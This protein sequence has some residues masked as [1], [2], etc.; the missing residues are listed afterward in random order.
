[1]G[2]EV[3]EK[4]SG[5]D[6]SSVGG[7]A[8]VSAQGERVRFCPEEPLV[9]DEGEESEEMTSGEAGQPKQPFPLM[10]PSPQY[11]SKWLSS[12]AHAAVVNGSGQVLQSTAEN[13]ERLSSA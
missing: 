10:T 4:E 2:A 8:R 9:I 5:E 6:L 1:M 3:R 12:A 11:G 7:S 13:S